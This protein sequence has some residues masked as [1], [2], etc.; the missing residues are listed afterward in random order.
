MR[1][2]ALRIERP[3]VLEMIEFDIQA[4]GPDDILVKTLACGIC[5]FELKAYLGEVP[6]E[7]PFIGGHEGIG[8]VADKG[9]KVAD[10]KVGDLVTTWSK[11]AFA[12]YYLIPRSR[13]VKIASNIKEPEFWISEPPKCAT[14][15][16]THLGVAPGNN[17]VLIGC[18]YMG[19]LHLQVL[20]KE[21]LPNLI[22]IDLSER[23]LQLAQRFG[24]THT[25]AVK[26]DHNQEVLAEVQE[27]C[28]GRVD[29]VIEAAG[30]SNALEL[31]GNMLRTAGILSI[32]GFHTHTETIDT[33]QWHLKGLRVFNTSPGI[34]NFSLDDFYKAVALMKR[35]IFNQRPLI[36]HKYEF[37]KGIE[38]IKN[39]CHE[40]PA[41]YIKGV[42]IFP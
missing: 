9:E 24:A 20:P 32:Y 35:G 26:P 39:L 27:I 33:G 14:T 30:S 4:P 17:L 19:L 40:R 22:A 7:Y 8:I 1:V 28:D 5:W 21:W 10:L 29:I 15:A 36:S 42:F 12:D 25:I 37:K 2:S 38:V 31:A 16:T 18:G 6:I 41:D 11:A 34:S 13:A 3:K 23:Q